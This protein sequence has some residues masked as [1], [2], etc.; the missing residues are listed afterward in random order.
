MFGVGAECK[1]DYIDNE[2]S[3]NYLVSPDFTQTPRNIPRGFLFGN[4]AQNPL[5]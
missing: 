3:S 5:G 2:P 1:L 4:N